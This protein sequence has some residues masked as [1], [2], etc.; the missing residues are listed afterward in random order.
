[1]KDGQIPDLSEREQE[2]LELMIEGRSND[3][4]ALSLEITRRTVEFHV[5]NILVKLDVTSRT[6]AVAAAVQ[7]G[8][9]DEGE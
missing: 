7:K 6:Q 5:T 3:Q 4:I 8:W 9:F 1:M 2:V